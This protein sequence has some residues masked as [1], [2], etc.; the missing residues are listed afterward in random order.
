MVM[1]YEDIF[2]VDYVAYTIQT[3]AFPAINMTFVT[4]HNSNKYTN[5]YYMDNRRAR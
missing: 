5:A 2:I 1:L 3:K 4:L